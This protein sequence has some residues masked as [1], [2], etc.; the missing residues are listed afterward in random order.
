M[1]KWIGFDFNVSIVSIVRL[2]T[3]LLLFKDTALDLISS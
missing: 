1:D 3:F 2:N